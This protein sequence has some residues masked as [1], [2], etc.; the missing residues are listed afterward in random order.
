VAR[1][2]EH[3]ALELA[4]ESEDQVSLCERLAAYFRERPGQ[5]IDGHALLDIGGTFAF[6]TRL[7]ELRRPPF[8]MTIENQ[9]TR[10][11]FMGRKWTETKYRY[12]VQE[13]SHENTAAPTAHV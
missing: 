13:T 9:T 1:E 8:N 5:W 6:R 10:H 12:T 7:S 11:E 3:S 2:L 4:Y